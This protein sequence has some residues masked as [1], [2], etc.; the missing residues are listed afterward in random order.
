MNQ[1]NE[2]DF[3]DLEKVGDGI[4]PFQYQEP[5]RDRRKFSNS[6]GNHN[7]IK[8]KLKE[9]ANRKMNYNQNYKNQNYELESSFGSTSQNFQRKA[10]TPNPFKTPDPASNM[11]RSL[12]EKIIGINDIQSTHQKQIEKKRRIKKVE[13]YKT[14]LAEIKDNRIGEDYCSSRIH[15][16]RRGHNLSSENNLI[17]D[18]SSES[19]AIIG[20]LKNDNSP[21][22]HETFYRDHDYNILIQEN[23]QLRFLMSD[24]L[25]EIDQ[26]RYAY[27]KMRK[28]YS[29]S[30]KENST[31]KKKVENLSLY[32]DTLGRR[33]QNFYELKKN[34]MGERRKHRSQETVK[35]KQ[36]SFDCD[37]FYGND[38]RK[39]LKIKASNSVFEDTPN[40]RN[41]KKT[42]I[43]AVREK[44][45][46]MKSFKERLQEMKKNKQ[47]GGSYHL[48]LK[49][50][51]ILSYPDPKN[52]EDNYSKK[53]Q[54]QNRAYQ[55]FLRSSKN[56]HK[57]EARILL[58]KNQ[59]R[60][61]DK[62]WAKFVK[63]EDDQRR[64]KSLRTAPRNHY[65][66]KHKHMKKFDN[67]ILLK[68]R[69]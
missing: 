60:H 28:K 9:S 57:K 41:Q 35:S 38:E 34:E 68:N 12:K 58:S 7:D 31:L 27:T 39:T 24:Y 36:K 53:S 21:P 11:R 8:K 55:N 14:K 1:D 5:I 6:I 3:I 65:H 59:G 19:F 37:N 66:L 2:V 56:F 10:S 46:M 23:R 44:F 33:K 61:P 42:S 52:Q 30:K 50:R 43:F 29:R 40:R 67:P 54:K 25:K 13:K 62:N 64:Q 63:P 49:S 32:V 16:T 17:G 26:I 51:N 69:E 22:Y 4:R 47:H 15:N 45:N 18:S 48:R 20:N